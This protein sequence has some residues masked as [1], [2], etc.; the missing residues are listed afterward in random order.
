MSRTALEINVSQRVLSLIEQEKN[1][2]HLESHIWLRIHIVYYSIEGKRNIDIA[3]ELR[4]HEKTV[5]KWRKRFWEHQQLLEVYEQGHGESVPTDKELVN[6]LKEALSDAPRA[7][8]PV[9]LSETDIN[10][11]VALA[12]EKPENHGLPF[13]NWTHGEL[14]Q[15]ANKM[16]I[17][18]SPTHLGRILKKRAAAT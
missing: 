10:R 14:A 18:V 12:C 5:R 13:S 11:L 3:H 9:R 15:Q 8:A 1:R 4:C 7:G 6:K 2:R 16:G 17:P